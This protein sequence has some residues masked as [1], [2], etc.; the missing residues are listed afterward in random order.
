MK[1][2]IFRNLDKK[3]SFF[4]KRKWHTLRNSDKFTQ[5]SMLYG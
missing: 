2:E 3:W 5:T 1:K 4:S